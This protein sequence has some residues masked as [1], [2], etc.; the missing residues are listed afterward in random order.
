MIPAMSIHS[1]SAEYE[2]GRSE[3]VLKR[4]VPD[5]QKAATAFTAAAAARTSAAFRPQQT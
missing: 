1:V 3:F 5:I 4:V 2:D